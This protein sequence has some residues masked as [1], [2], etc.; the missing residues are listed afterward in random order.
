[1]LEYG[2]GNGRI[3]LPLARAGCS[4][5]GVDWSAP[6]L[7]DMARRLLDEPPAVAR[8]VRGVAGDMRDLQLGKRFPLVICPFNTFLHLYAREDVERFFARVREHLTPG[9]RFVFDV[10]VPQPGDL[11]RDPNR[12]YGAPRFRYPSTGQMVRYAE[13][14]D[15]DAARQILFVTMEFTPVDGGD[16][17]VVPLAHRQFFPQ[18]LEALLHYNGFDLTSVHGGFEGEPLDRFSDVSVWT[19]R[20][21]RS[22]PSR[23]A[24]SR[25]APSRPAPASRASRPKK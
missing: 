18:E 7:A 3:A 12:A 4:V 13:R 15:Y 2:V 19:A 11:D 24:P 8:R 6:M 22:A 1:V 14:F 9:G 17:W 23:P 20:L 25:S 16:P 21:S 5:T 10:S